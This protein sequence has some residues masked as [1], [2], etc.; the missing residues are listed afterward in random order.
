MRVYLHIGVQFTRAGRLLKAVRL[1][2]KVYR[3]NKV[4]APSVAAYRPKIDQMMDTLDGLPP[5]PEETRHFLAELSEDRSA[6]AIVLVDE[7]LCGELNRAFEETMLYPAMG[8]RLARVAELFAAA[9]LKLSMAITNPVNFVGHAMQKKKARGVAE[10][11]ARNVPP[12]DV[13]WVPAIDRLQEALPDVPLTIWCEEDT[14]FIWRRLLRRFGELSEDADLRAP[15]MALA[16]F[17][18]SEG[19]KRFVTYARK[20]PPKDDVTLERIALA[21]LDKY[22][23][24]ETVGPAGG[25]DGWD[26]T[27]TATITA[28]YE[29]DIEVLSKRDGITFV[30]PYLSEDDLD[31]QAPTAI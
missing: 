8:K 13:S 31:D 7:R 6:N 23:I 1:N 17:L 27:A 29:D 19:A 24:I 25:I 4:I 18:N 16:D 9:D 10:W 28:G 12:A 30:R 15:H 22:E 2:E 14:P 5:T 21:F 11:F 3:R 26:E 20:F